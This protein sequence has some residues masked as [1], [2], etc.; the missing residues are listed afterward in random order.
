VLLP[1]YECAVLPGDVAAGR[2]CGAEQHD[3]AADADRLSSGATEPPWP[4]KPRSPASRLGFDNV[5]VIGLFARTGL[6]LTAQ[7]GRARPCN[8]GTLFG[9]NKLFFCCCERIWSCRD[10][11]VGVEARHWSWAIAGAS[12]PRLT[13]RSGLHTENHVIIESRWPDGLCGPQHP[14][15]GCH[16]IFSE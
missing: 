2:Q 5:G 3:H 16:V 12:T 9:K 14:S 4:P 15:D 11:W 10:R 13:A 7:F 1:L 6:G 8:L